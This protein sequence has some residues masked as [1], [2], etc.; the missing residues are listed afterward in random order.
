MEKNESKVGNLRERSLTSLTQNKP[1]TH[2]FSWLSG[3]KFVFGAGG[4][5]FKSQAGQIEHS[6][7]NGSPSLR[8]FFKKSCVGVLPGHNDAE[9]GP[10]NSLHALAY[11]NEYN[12]RKKRPCAQFAT[13]MIMKNVFFA[14]KLTSEKKKNSIAITNSITVTYSRGVKQHGRVANGLQV[15]QPPRNITFSTTISSCC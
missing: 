14:F 8:H 9:I 1:T 11:Y 15:K 10:A 7:A 2:Q 3:N 6:V 13:M 4:L 5:R 12:K